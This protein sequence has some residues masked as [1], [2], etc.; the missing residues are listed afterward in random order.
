[1]IVDPPPYRTIAR[2][3]LGLARIAAP[4]GRAELWAVNRRV[5]P[6][7]TCARCGAP[8]PWHYRP[9]LARAPCL[10]RLCRPCVEGAAEGAASLP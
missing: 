9:A 10:P 5:D 4:D 6:A 8:A 3:A 7:A 2:V 1:M